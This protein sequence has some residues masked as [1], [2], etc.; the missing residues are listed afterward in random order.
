[1]LTRES[2]GVKAAWAE[3][4]STVRPARYNAKGAGNDTGEVARSEQFRDFARLT[5]G[6]TDRA[7]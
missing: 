1:M 7:D 4:G 6:S 5:S 3:V 2:V